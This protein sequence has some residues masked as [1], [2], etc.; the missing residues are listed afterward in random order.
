M[1]SVFHLIAILAV[2]SFF[3][4]PFQQTLAQEKVSVEA[5]E[6]QAF[7]Q[8]AAYVS[9][10]IVRILTTGG[11]D[12]VGR[13][14]TGTGPTTGV[15]VSSDGYVIS[16]AFNFA[17]QPS[18]ILVELPDER[19]F[20]A[21]L[22]ATDRAR[23]LTLLKIEVENLAPAKAAE[24]TAFQ[25]GQW[26][27]A[28]GRT[29]NNPQ[30]SI[31]VGIIS[32]LNRVWG[33]AV[34]TDA[35]VSPI[36]YGG[37]LVNIEGKVIGILVPLSMKGNGATAGV[38][39]Y[40]SGIGFA[41]PMEDVYA[42]L[43]RLKTGKDLNP[44][45][46]GITMRGRDFL[47]GKPII[48]LVRAGS[49]AEKAGIRKGDTIIEIDGKPIYRQAEVKQALGNK[50]A[51]EKVRVALQR[52]KETIQAEVTLVGKLLAFESGFLGILPA[53]NPSSRD[54]SAGVAIRYVYPDSPAAKAG[55]Q[56]RDGIVRFNDSEVSTPESLTDLISR[57]RP[58][59][60]ATLVYLR[61]NQE[62]TAQL[63]LAPIP[64]TIPRE[65]L[66]SIILS[67]ENPDD[68][69]KS[70]A[71]KTG[72]ITVDM[73]N[74][75]QSYWAYIPDDYN[76]DYKYGLMVWIH[77]NGDTME[78]EIL[79]HWKLICQQRGLLLLAPKAKKVKAWNRDEAGFVKDAIAH[80]SETYSVDPR[81]TFL[82]G[83]GK[84]GEFTFH[85]AFKFR[86]VFRGI[87]IVNAT[88]RQPPPENHPDYRIQIHLAGSPGTPDY[89]AIR[90][91]ATRLREMKYPV[92]LTLIEEGNNGYPTGDI[93][94]EIGRWA[95]SLDRL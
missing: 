65:L 15:V 19:R 75:Q 47:A 63:T 81:R 59:Q 8:A 64:N 18:S 90:S 38:E 13:V 22:V 39:W 24:K 62:Q 80:F 78:A 42:T 7:K 70:K 31:S 36:N 89:P 32:A 57:V 9:P 72:R 73:P 94:L 60:N 91:L 76:S 35:K 6:E 68:K 58:G 21:R 48:D 84:G 25:V 79:D 34:Q 77:P 10:S 12:R 66:T 30:P 33:R 92:S 93:L 20:P 1:K 67:P 26:A 85:L 83:Y 45:L 11:Q 29:F 3:V 16:S 46:M 53:R 43:E 28:L 86:E 50:Y 69:K 55:L 41:I 52:N 87:A 40:D 14:L 17:S 5:L 54:D 95:D 88:L 37:P 44:G 27:I 56:P 49:P 82:H 51:D 23:M 71:P 2:V 4:T 61:N 74:Y